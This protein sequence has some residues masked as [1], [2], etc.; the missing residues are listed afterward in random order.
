M[1]TLLQLLNKTAAGELTPQNIPLDFQPELLPKRCSCT[2]CFSKTHIHSIN[3]GRLRVPFPNP[4]E[5]LTILLV[6]SAS[7]ANQLKFLL[8]ESITDVTA[9]NSAPSVV[10]G[11]MRIL[12]E[13]ECVMTPLNRSRC[14]G[15]SCMNSIHVFHQALD[16]CV[17]YTPSCHPILSL[18]RAALLSSLLVAHKLS[19]FCAHPT[20]GL[21][22]QKSLVMYSVCK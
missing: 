10:P 1:W 22:L 12:K 6:Q 5:I 21:D 11:I 20:T 16:Q 18:C 3:H 8:V 2:I 15:I 4:E 13:H 19:S 17:I 9:T 14:T 7:E